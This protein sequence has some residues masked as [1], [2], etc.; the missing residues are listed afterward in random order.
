VCVC[1]HNNI[2]CAKLLTLCKGWRPCDNDGPY[3]CV[4]TKRYV[5]GKCGSIEARWKAALL[6]MF[7][8][9]VDAGWQKKRRKKIVKYKKGRPFFSLHSFYFCLSYRHN[10]YTLVHNGSCLFLFF[11]LTLVCLV[12][13]HHN[14]NNNNNNNIIATSTASRAIY[15]I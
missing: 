7:V 13:Q 5:W 15:V 6:E 3:T 8:Q 1:V 10:L 4:H 12:R 11:S 9:C 14:N 2:L